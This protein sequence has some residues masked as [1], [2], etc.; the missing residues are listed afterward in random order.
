MNESISV[1]RRPGR[2]GPPAA[3]TAAAIIATAAL[4]LLAAACGASPPSTGSGGS[5]HPGGSSS[6]SPAIAFSRCMRSNGVSRFPDP[7]PDSGGGIPKADA[8]R[9]GVSS[10]QL[11]AAESACQHLLPSTGSIDQQTE[12][13]MTAGDCPPALVQQVLNLERSF[14]QCMRSHGVPN[15]PDPTLDSQGR[16]VFIISI[17]RD[18]GGVDPHT[19]QMTAEQDECGRLTG[20]PEPRQLNP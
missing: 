2:P 9:L 5:S 18:L 8:Q 6:T 14:A 1:T 10:S 12:Q 7:D 11:Q 4:A 17:S 15:W 20:S 13:C 19:A 3:R 16:P